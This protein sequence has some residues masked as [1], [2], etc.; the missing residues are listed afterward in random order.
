MVESVGK[1]GARAGSLMVMGDAGQA[2]C[3]AR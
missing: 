3:V 1:V 2:K